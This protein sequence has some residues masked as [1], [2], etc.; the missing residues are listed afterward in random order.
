MNNQ[1]LTLDEAL[2]KHLND[3]AVPIPLTMIEACKL[4][5]GFIN[6]GEKDALVDLPSNARFHN[7][8]KNKI[9]YAIPAFK[10]AMICHLDDFLADKDGW[11][12]FV[13]S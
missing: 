4:A 9:E 13:E 3:H 12:K 5:I 7:I 6:R 8:V 1:T 10:I 2:V 11:V